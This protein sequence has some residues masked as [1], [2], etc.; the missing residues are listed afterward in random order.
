MNNRNET[1]FINKVFDEALSANG[2]KRGTQR[3]QR[4]KKKQIENW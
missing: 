1:E 2:I 4:G 3:A